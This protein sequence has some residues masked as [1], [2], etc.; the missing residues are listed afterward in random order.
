MIEAYGVVVT[1]IALWIWIL[2]DTEHDRLRVE[3]ARL[4]WSQMWNKELQKSV[5]S[6]KYERS[7]LTETAN[8]DTLKWF[9]AD[10]VHCGKNPSA[11]APDCRCAL[12]VTDE[13]KS[14]IK[15]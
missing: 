13:P 11:P 14:P 6:L 3:S 1:F 10:C 12:C 7:Q 15:E 2:R 5:D 9:R 8:Y 4:R